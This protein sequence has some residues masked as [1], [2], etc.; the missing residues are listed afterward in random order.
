MRRRSGGW[1]GDIRH[2]HTYAQKRQR[3]EPNADQSS[4][5]QYFRIVLFGHNASRNR[6]ET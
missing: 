3:R 2:H 4:F 6:Y 5:A 1:W